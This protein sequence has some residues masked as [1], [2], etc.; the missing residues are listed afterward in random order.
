MAAPT[1]RAANL[2][3]PGPWLVRGEADDG[4]SAR[5]AMLGIE[6]ATEEGSGGWTYLVSRIESSRSATVPCTLRL[7]SSASPMPS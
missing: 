6:P 2:P 1:L 4:A 5:D 7:A 3:T